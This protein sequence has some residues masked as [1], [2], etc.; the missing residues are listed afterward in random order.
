MTR[1]TKPAAAIP[2]TMNVPGYE[3][4]SLALH[5]AYDQAARGKGKER[6]ANERPFM[7]QPMNVINLQ[8]D[9]IDGYVYQVH[10][11]SLEAKGLPLERAQAEL[12]GAIN[13]AA[14]AW[15]HLEAKRLAQ[16][17]K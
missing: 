2:A 15:L 9:S 16:S 1:V 4:L 6:H 13:Y 17:A 11:K 12:L 5:A 7:E 8:L 10:K 14:G 3:S